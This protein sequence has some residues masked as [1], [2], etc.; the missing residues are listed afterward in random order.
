MT[1]SVRDA[2]ILVTGGAGFIGSALVRHLV[3]ARDLPVVNVDLLTYAG[4]RRSV[5]AAEASPHYTFARADVANATQVGALLQLHRPRAIVHLA[6]ESHVDRSIAGPAAFVHT[7]VVGTYTLLE[8]ATR[9]WRTLPPDARDA[10]RFVHVSTDEVF[11][12]AEDGAVFTGTSPYRPSSPYAASKAASDHFARAWHRTY[13]LPVIVT[14]STNNYG[15][16]QHPEKLIPLVLRQA[17]A[18]AA[19]P[20]YGH[21]MQVRDWMHVDDHVRGLV[22]ALEQGVA[23]ET[24]LFGSHAPHSNLDI[25]ARLCALLDLARPQGAPHA[26][27]VTHVAD[28]P[29]HDERYALATDDTR[30]VLGWSPE[31]SLDEGLRRTVAWYLD[32]QAWVEAMLD[33]D[34]TGQ[35]SSPGQAA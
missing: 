12:S 24:Y 14:T 32:N 6:A 26:R 27:L 15:P 33:A 23:G 5:E 2:P 18:G 31:I 16:R 11:G 7:N 22:A 21:G 20:I 29:G 17:L 8:Q 1:L 9:Y 4:Q 13:G 34:T 10:F 3:L 28:R 30:G 35:P 19:I 25:V